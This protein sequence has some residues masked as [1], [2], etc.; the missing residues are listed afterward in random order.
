M[1]NG[2]INTLNEFVMRVKIIK[3]LEYGYINTW[4]SNNLKIEDIP[5]DV[6]MDLFYNIEN[7][8]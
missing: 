2:Y 5:D 3:N 1:N 7:R 4:F 8:I 6:I